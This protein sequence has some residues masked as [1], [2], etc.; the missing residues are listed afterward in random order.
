MTAS[1]FVT[2]EVGFKYSVFREVLMHKHARLYDRGNCSGV[3][4]SNSNTGD[5]V[6]L[7]HELYDV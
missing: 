1:S 6:F 2:A 7:I 5:T 4:F 3:Q